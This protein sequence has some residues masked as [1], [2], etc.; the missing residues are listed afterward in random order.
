MELAQISRKKNVYP[1]GLILSFFIFFRHELFLL[2]FPPA[3][4]ESGRII[5]DDASPTRPLLLTAA[6]SSSKQ[7]GGLFPHLPFRLGR[8]PTAHMIWF[9]CC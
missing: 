2:I 3:A 4:G 5:D 9:A 8:P 6:F 1:L 7:K